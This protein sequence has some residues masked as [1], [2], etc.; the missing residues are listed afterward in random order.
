M[1]NCTN[2]EMPVGNCTADKAYSQVK[3]VEMRNLRFSSSRK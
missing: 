3:L 1:N 2:N